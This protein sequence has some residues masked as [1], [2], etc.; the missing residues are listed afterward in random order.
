[1]QLEF[2][3][4][5][6][7]ADPTQIEQVILNMAVN[8]RD[9]MP[10]GGTLSISTRQVHVTVEDTRAQSLPHAGAYIIIEISDTGCGMDAAVREHL[11]EP[12]FTTKGPDHGTGLGL[13]TSYG[14]VVQHGGQI[15]VESTPGL[16]ASFQIYLPLEEDSS[17][18]SDMNAAETLLP[19]GTET[20][21]LAEDEPT[22]RELI[23][24]VLR[25]L[26]YTVLEAPD[27]ISA[28][29]LGRVQPQ[30]DLLISDLVMPGLGGN[31]LLEALRARFPD[32]IV[33]FTSGYTNNQVW[34][35]E[36]LTAS[37]HFLQKPFAPYAL[38]QR[39]RT[40]LDKKR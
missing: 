25:G 21:L 8:A 38:A 12:F 13:A 30:I 15:V 11:F 35:S 4:A 40:L 9:A 22:V 28:L 2:E 39:V 36:Q 31:A 23:G 32:L 37:E 17:A 34:Y 33:L 18:H 24:R 1:M 5:I 10:D 7:K 29:G 14:I 27:G 3:D 26:G 19:R 16:G 6:I 20:I